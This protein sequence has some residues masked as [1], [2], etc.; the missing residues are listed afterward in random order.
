MV[1]TNED[2]NM[3]HESDRITQDE[4][5]LDMIMFAIKAIDPYQVSNCLCVIDTI[6]L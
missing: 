6:E 5:S 3:R 2:Q 4:L 1:R